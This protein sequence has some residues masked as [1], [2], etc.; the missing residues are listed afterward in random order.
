LADADL[1]YEL[2]LPAFIESLEDGPGNRVRIV[3]R[4]ATHVGEPVG[5]E[6]GLD[7]PAIFHD[8]RPLIS[9]PGDRI[10]ALTWHDYVAYSVISESY[11]GKEA[12]SP[13]HDGRVVHT[14]GASHFLDYVRKASFA[15]D[16][17]PGPLLHHEIV[18]EQHVVNL[19]SD[20][21][22]EVRTVSVQ[23]GSEPSV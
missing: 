23:A 11:A 5:P 8:A 9:G 20:Q 2:R 6:P 12:A 18:T 21:P 22:P 3:I 1:L 19:V 13:P 7:I 15:S 17:Y 14:F 16:E 4:E 10:V